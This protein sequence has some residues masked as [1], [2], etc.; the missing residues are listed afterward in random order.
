MLGVARLM[1]ALAKVKCN[2]LHLFPILPHS[3]HPCGK[4]GAIRGAKR[5]K[6]QSK[7]K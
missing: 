7:I 3:A 2:T 5:A 4:E 1:S 6:I